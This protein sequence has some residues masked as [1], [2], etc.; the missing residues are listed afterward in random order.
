M[1]KTRIITRNSSGN[2]KGSSDDRKGRL[3]SLRTMCAGHGK[4]EA[5]AGVIVATLLLLVASLV[6]G[7][8]G[9]GTGET[10]PED[11]EQGYYQSGSEEGIGVADDA[12]TAVICKVVVTPGSI[13]PQ[14]TMVP[15]SST[16]TTNGTAGTWQAFHNGSL[17][18]SG[19]V[20]PSEGSYNHKWAGHHGPVPFTWQYAHNH[21]GGGYGYAQKIFSYDVVEVHRILYV[22]HNVTYGNPI[23][24]PVD[25]SVTLKAIPFT[26][27]WPSGQPQW[28]GTGLINTNGDVTQIDTS[29]AGIYVADATCGESV[30]ERTV[31]AVRLDINRAGGGAMANPERVGITAAGNDRARNYDL[32][33]TPAAEANNV[34]VTHSQNLMVIQ[35]ATTVAGNVATIPLQVVGAV[36]SVAAGDG[37][38]RAVHGLSQANVQRPFSVVIPAQ[39]GTPHPQQP[40]IQATGTNQ[41]LTAASV[42]PAQGLADG[43]VM[44]ATVYTTPLTIIVW[45]QF[46]QLIGD[47]YVGATIT[48]FNQ[49][50]MNVALAADSTYVDTV[51]FPIPRSGST[52][53]PGI[54]AA[55]SP[56]AQAWPNAATAAPG[57][58]M[59]SVQNVAVQVDG[60]ALNPAIVNRIVAINPNGFMIVDW[61]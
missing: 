35:G 29:K 55:N 11:T 36:A 48:E 18:A 23:Y 17:A 22:E 3:R 12:V 49:L 58:Q 45:D 43:D 47:I 31:I 20:Y 37:W 56:E 25:T 53:G 9:M 16:Q 28:S 39:I 6:M 57:E 60:F 1:K 27:V 2:E 4:F 51:G 26:S 19:I 13:D 42:P 59:I 21:P 38:I 10:A 50:P 30:Q 7:A 14:E 34:A 44:L 15:V 33:I 32:T 52:K 5:G 40:G 61:P 41:V 46:Q 54:F 24:V 8:C